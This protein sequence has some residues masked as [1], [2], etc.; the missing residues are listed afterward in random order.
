MTVSSSA[1]TD[2]LARFLPVHTTTNGLTVTLLG[3]GRVLAVSFRFPPC[4][5]ALFL[6]ERLFSVPSPTGSVILVWSAAGM[7]MMSPGNS[8]A[9]VYGA[10]KQFRATGNERKMM[11]LV[12]RAAP[13]LTKTPSNLSRC[14]PASAPQRGSAVSHPVRDP[15]R[16]T[17]FLARN[18]R[19]AS[20]IAN[21]RYGAAAEPD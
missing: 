1:F 4:I 6:L 20:A 2:P 14:G 10:K 3:V 12:A 13:L 15:A 11:K 16:K 7:I 9:G 19:N 18:T 5:F 17:P 8:E 21:L